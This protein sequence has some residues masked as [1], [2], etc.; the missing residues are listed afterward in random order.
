MLDEVQL[1]FERESTLRRNQTKKYGRSNT[2]DSY[3]EQDQIQ[4]KKYIPHQSS[5]DGHLHSD[6]IDADLYKS[7]S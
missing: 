5:F 2:L 3:L 1:Q 7:Y 4:T 6:G